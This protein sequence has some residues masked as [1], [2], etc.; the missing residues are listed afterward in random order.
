[1]TAGR[2]VSPTT[3]VTSRSEAVRASQIQTYPLPLGKDG[4]WFSIQEAARAFNVPERTLR[5]WATDGLVRTR[6]RPFG[7][8]RLVWSGDVAAQLRA[9]HEKESA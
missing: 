5:T 7:K 2:A 3:P 4:L 9:R 6:P 1:M 8:G